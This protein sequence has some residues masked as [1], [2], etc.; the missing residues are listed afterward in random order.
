MLDARQEKEEIILRR[1]VHEEMARV[2][3]RLGGNQ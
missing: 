3:K 2:T 1:I